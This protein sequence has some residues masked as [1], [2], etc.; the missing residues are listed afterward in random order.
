L[1]DPGY[2]CDSLAQTTTTAE[3]DSG[4][5]CLSGATQASYSLEETTEDFG[6]CPLDHYCEQG[7]SIPTHCGTGYWS[8]N[9]FGLNAQ[10]E[11]SLCPAGYYCDANDLSPQPTGLCLEGWYCPEGSIE[12]AP[13]DTPCDAGYFCPTGSPDQTICPAGTYQTYGELGY[14]VPC[15]EGYY[16]EAGAVATQGCPEGHYC[17]E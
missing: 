12:E 9:E 6:I 7:S 1:C 14:C 10:N 2:Y 16:C 11:C 4:S 3:C 17:P 5:F 15:P 8:N 13:V